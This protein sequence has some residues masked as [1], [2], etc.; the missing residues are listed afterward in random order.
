MTP[1]DEHRATPYAWYAL[2]ILF[3]VYSLNF[4]DRQ[5]LSILAEGIKRDLGMRDE[6][7]GFLYGT[8]FG[9]F[10]ALFGIPFGRLA[11]HWHRIRLITVGLTVWSMM[12]ALSGFAQN[13]VQLAVAR[14]GVGVGE[15]AANPAAYSLIADWFPKRLRATALSIYSAGLYLGGGLSLAVGGIVVQIWD[16]AYPASPPLGLAGWQVAFLLVG[17]PGLLLALWVSTLREPPREHAGGNSAAIDTGSLRFFMDELVTIIPPFTVLGAARLGWRA[18]VLNL[19]FAMLIV[20][21][22]VAAHA[23]GE[24]PV[25]WGAVGVGAYA[26]F[27][28]ALA[29]RYRDRPAFALIIANPAVI[30]IIV[31][32]G[33]ISLLAYTLSFWAAPYVMREFQVPPAEAG[34]MVGVV[35]T[36]G[37]FIG[38]SAGGLLADRLRQ[39]WPSGRIVMIIFGALVPAPFIAFGFTTE[40]V[41]AFYVCLFFALAISST[42][43]G[44]SGAS[45]Q[46]L[47]LPRMRGTATAIFFIGVTMLGLATGPYM[48][49]RVSTLTGDLATGVISMLVV[50]PVGVACAIA[51]Y[52]LFEKA[53]RDR[54][55]AARAAGEIL[56]SASH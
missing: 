25:Q 32:Y 36:I 7:L 53:E 49:G 39:L 22:V 51:A 8:A 1:S 35:G 26:I 44:A 47:V 30:C 6:D 38:V 5:I 28:W 19:M 29:L 37:G 31:A 40:N 42:A 23:G 55:D 54:H 16:R 18:L 13:G 9:V 2:G 56:S 34:L 52:A 3:L 14:V 4:V 15:A 45:I 11:D 48:A 41:P 33:L 50:V 20:L 24:S 43:L 12:T 17:V 27:S 46:D 21:L 10:Y